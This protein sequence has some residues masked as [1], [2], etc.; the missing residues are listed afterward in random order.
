MLDT[1]HGRTGE[2]VIMFVVLEIG[3]AHEYAWIQMGV[4]K[5]KAMTMNHALMQ[6][7]Q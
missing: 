3:T 5:E 2:N 1:V 7:V 4:Q 6:S